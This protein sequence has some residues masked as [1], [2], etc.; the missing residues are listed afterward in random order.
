MSKNE[1]IPFLSEIKEVIK[2]TDIEYTFRMSYEGDVKPGQFFEVSMP[3]YGEAPI[4]V[5][6]IGE[7][8][9]D[10][11]IRRVGKVTNEVFEH[12]VGDKLF[13]RG[14]YGNGFD[15][16]NYKNKE[17]V[18]VAGGTGV[19]P[20]RGVVEYFARNSKEAKGVTLIAGFKTPKDILFK[21]DFKQWKD[22][23]NIILTVDSAEGDANFK[24]G[25]VTKYIPE[26]ELKNVEEAS[27]IVVGPPAMMRFS[28]QG[29]LNVGF[30]EENIWISQ[31]RKMCCGIGKCGHC[32]IDDVYVCLDGPVFNF[33]KGKNLID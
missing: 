25:L 3:K 11:T 7:N 26:L 28:T 32:K 16:E 4:S 2:H 14:P 12:Y 23:V 29:L 13:L 24:E 27:A 8:T 17:I 1:Y 10:F 21:D 9:I 22:N 15:V 19:S 33:T 31:E 30:K 18:I 20:V 6:G 5:S